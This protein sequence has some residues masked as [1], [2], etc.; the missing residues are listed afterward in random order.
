MYVETDCAFS[1]DVVETLI[2][3]AAEFYRAALEDAEEQEP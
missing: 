2:R 1:P 3:Q